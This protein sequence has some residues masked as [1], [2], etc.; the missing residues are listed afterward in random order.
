[1]ATAPPSPTPPPAP[2]EGNGTVTV[3]WK[4]LDITDGT[5]EWRYGIRTLAWENVEFV[6]L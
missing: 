6:F 3:T 2:S 4:E 5:V 1:M